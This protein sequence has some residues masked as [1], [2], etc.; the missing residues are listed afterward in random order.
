MFVKG[1]RSLWGTGMNTEGQ[2]GDKTNTTRAL[3]VKILDNVD[4][5]SAGD[6]HTMIITTDGNLWATGA[7]TYGQ[8]GIG[9]TISK[10]E[11]VLS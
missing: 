5:V 2:L 6:S 1:D 8:L 11:R 7:N 9:N 3:P 4:S 10:N